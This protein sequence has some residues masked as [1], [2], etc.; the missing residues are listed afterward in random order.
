MAVK[1][2]VGVERRGDTLRIWFRYQGKKVHEKHPAPCTAAG[3]DSAAR[4]RARIVAQIDAGTF[5]YRDWFANSPRAEDTTAPLFGH[6]AQ[7]W[8]NRS[9]QDLAKST[10]NG[11]LKKLNPYWLPE[12]SH[13]PIDQI[14]T[15][16][17]RDIAAELE[18]ISPKTYND[19]LTPLRAIFRCAQED[20]LITINPADALKSR[21]RQKPEPDPLTTDEMTDVLDWLR[22]KEPHWQPYFSTAF[23]TGLRTSELIALR[24]EDIDQRSGY[25]RVKQAYVSGEIKGCKTYHARDVEF[26]PMTREAIA[27]QRS[28]TQLVSDEH[29]SLVFRGVSGDIITGDKPPRLIWTRALRA[30]KVRHRPAYN[31]RHTYATRAILAK[32]NVAWLSKQMGHSSIKMTFDHYATWVNRID[33]GSERAKLDS[34]AGN[35]GNDLGNGERSGE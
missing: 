16:E 33:G 2:H 31:T 14:S 12:L 27:A 7:T 30:C 32:C 1:K 35:L 11:Y 9:R 6:V 26:G 22:K 8:L 34:L 25:I 5:V 19:S 24:W 10:L 20:R 13:R 4:D 23:D 18:G 15:G 17:L 21:K 3:L 28:K 29:G